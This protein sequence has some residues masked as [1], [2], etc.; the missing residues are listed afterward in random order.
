MGPLITPRLRAQ[1]LNLIRR[2]RN[3][4]EQDFSDRSGSG[5][6]TFTEQRPLPSASCT[7]IELEDPMLRCAR[8][9]AGR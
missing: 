1:S 7:G 4:T 5:L 8:K 3:L 9:S 6:V 2:N